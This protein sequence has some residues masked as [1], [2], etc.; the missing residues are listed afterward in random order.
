MTIK[1]QPIISKMTNKTGRL[2]RTHQNKLYITFE[3]DTPISIDLMNY[4][5]YL[6]INSKY[7][8]KYLK[9]KTSYLKK[10][11]EKSQNVLT[12]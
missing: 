5:K 9:H 3:Y 1:N 7:V 11:L 4:Q 10:R 12:A 6:I 2:I 8:Q